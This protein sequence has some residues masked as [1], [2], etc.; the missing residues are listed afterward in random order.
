MG[1]FLWKLKTQSEFSLSKKKTAFNNLVIV[2]LCSAGI[3]LGHSSTLA[4]ALSTIPQQV[5]GG[6]QAC[7][8]EKIDKEEENRR[9]EGGETDGL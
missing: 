5:P 8:E 3:T 1:I 9:G 2:C 4:T 7:D 6:I